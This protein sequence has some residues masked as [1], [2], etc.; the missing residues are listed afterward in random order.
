MA[1][2]AIHDLVDILDVVA[3]ERPEFQRAPTLDVTDFEDAVQAAAALR[4]GADYL[5][6]RNERDFKG[7][8]VPTAKP[9]TLLSLL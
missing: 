5:V 2:Q 9:S 7:A 8:P 4:L 6:T 3:V 1:T